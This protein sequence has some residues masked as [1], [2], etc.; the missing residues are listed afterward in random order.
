MDNLIEKKDLGFI[1]F[2]KNCKRK[3]KFSDSVKTNEI[4]KAKVFRMK[5]EQRKIET[6]DNFKE[7]LRQLTLFTGVYECWERVKGHYPV[8]IPPILLA[9]KITYEAHMRAMHGGV[10][11]TIATI[12]ENYWISKLQQIAKRV[13]RKCFGC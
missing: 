11:M 3:E 7:D 5:H 9:E 10:I 6:T 13:I 8:Y 12:R 1:D 2:L 4:E